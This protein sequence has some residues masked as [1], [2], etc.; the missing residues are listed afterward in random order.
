MNSIVAPNVKRIIKQNCLKQAAIAE[1]AGYTPNQFSAMISGRKV[2]KDIDILKIMVMKYKKMEEASTE[3]L[4]RQICIKE[5]ISFTY[6]NQVAVN[7]L[8]EINRIVQIEK[9]D[10][11]FAQR[12]YNKDIKSRFT[13]LKNKCDRFIKEHPNSKKEIFA[14]LDELVGF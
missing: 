13:W 2:I 11:L 6:K 5:N 9:T 10:L 8:Q 7:A 14:F 12:L 3:L 1:K 4:A